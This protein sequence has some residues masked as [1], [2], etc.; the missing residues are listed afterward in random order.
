MFLTADAQIG[1]VVIPGAGPCLFCCDNGNSP[2]KQSQSLDNPPQ[3]R[4]QVLPPHTSH[5]HQLGSP[6]TLRRAFMHVSCAQRC[7][8]ETVSLKNFVFNL[9]NAVSCH[10]SSFE[11]GF[12]FHLLHCYCSFDPYFSSQFICY[13]LSP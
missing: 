6:A 8:S 2:P 13:Q 12:Y 9:T 1:R 3:G 5:T 4:H 7:P 10:M 11:V